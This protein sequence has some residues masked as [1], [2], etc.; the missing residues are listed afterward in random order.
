MKKS[1]FTESEI[2]A[3][4]QEG[5]AGLAVAEVCRKHGISSATYCHWKSKHSGVQ[6]SELQ[7]L[8][9]LESENARLKLL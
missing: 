2:V 7:R 6:L 3:A 8:R 1:R 5:E 4:L 9:E